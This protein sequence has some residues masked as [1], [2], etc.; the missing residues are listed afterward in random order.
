MNAEKLSIIVVTYNS[1]NDLHKFLPS[2]SS[3]TYKEFEMVVVD[4]NSQD[5]SVEIVKYYFPEAKIIR[6]SENL[7]FARAV[8][9]GIEASSGEFILLLNPDTRL[10]EDFIEIL[11]RKLEEH[12]EA[13][14]VCGKLLTE[15]GKKIDSAGIFFSPFLRHFD[16]GQGEEPEKY[17]EEVYVFGISGAAALFRRKMLE[18]V[19]FEKEY[20]DSSFFAYREDADLCWRAQ[21]LGWKFLYVPSAIGFHR[22]R[23][24]PGKRKNLPAFINMH[25]VKN[26]FLMRIKNQTL[27]LF[28]TLFFPSLIRDL[29]IIIYILLFERSS[30]K[31]FREVFSLLPRALKWRRKIMAEKRVSSLKI[32]PWFLWKKEERSYL[33]I[34]F[35]GTRGVPA[36]YS[37]FET[38]VEQTGKRLSKS[39]RVFVYNRSH[40]IKMKGEYLGMKL[41]RIPTIPLKHTDT[42]VHTFLSVIHGAFMGYDIVYICG[43]GNSIL[44]LIPR[45]YGAKTVLNVDGKDWARE[46]WGRFAKW[47]LKT[48]EK[49]ATIFPDVVIADSKAVEDYYMQT[50]RKKTVMIPY[51]AEIRYV[52]P[53]R[54]LQKFGLEPRKYIL[55]VGR[56]VPENGAHIII[57]AYKKIPKTSFPLVVVGDAPY[58]EKYK[59]ELKRKAEEVNPPKKVI[60][61]GFLVGDDY[62]EISSHPYIYV[63]ASGVGGTH[64]VLVEQM[65][66]G[67][68]VLVNSVNPANVEVV[69]NA[70]IYFDGKKG[71][72]DLKEKI[73]FLLQNPEIVER[74]RKL[75]RERVE[76]IYDWEKIAK[77]YEELFLLLKAGRKPE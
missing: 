46:K 29:G 47:F 17:N 75:A 33:K 43:V 73:E 26:R 63:L 65:K 53:S 62:M 67:N 12:P 69:E 11:V 3:Q 15:D 45:L 77:R 34:A 1:E 72:E 25:S 14:G 41:I 23:V 18:D 27:F 42:I 56:L 58:M 49:I 19:R 7:G 16:R 71:S 55:F 74:Y 20:F 38:F 61:T 44:S 36:A 30:L 31:A 37:G 2:I 24:F 76:R 60:F 54:C 8:N 51:G 13:G 5:R 68:C 70:G 52:P 32:L 9:Q 28:F 22:R 39:H 35:M 40:Y 64:P 50:Y 48:S 57:D 59:A 21:L 66:A 4:N 6:N 10:K